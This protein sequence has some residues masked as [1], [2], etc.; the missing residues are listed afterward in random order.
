MSTTSTTLLSTSYPAE[1]CT[2]ANDG[3]ITIPAGETSAQIEVTLSPSASDLEYVTTYMVPLQ[4]VAR[5]R[6]SS[7]KMRLVI[8]R[9]PSF[10]HW[11]EEDPQH[12]LLRGERLQPAQRH[13][14]HSGGRSAVLRCRR[15]L[16]WQH[17]LDASK[18]KV[19]MNANPNVQALLDN[20]EELL[21][22]LRKKVSRCCSTSWATMTRPASLV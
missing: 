5:R 15:A 17:Q 9:L 11:F 12:L 6:V 7:S 19:Y 18:Q 16:R 2:I 8:R 14:V 22:P 20:S 1:L 21:Q 3:V 13:R 4:A 10:A